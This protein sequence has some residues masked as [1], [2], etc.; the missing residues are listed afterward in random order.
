MTDENTQIVIGSGDNIEMMNMGDLLSVSFDDVEEYR[1]EN[2]PAG[3]YE[4]RVKE[5]GIGSQETK[6]GVKAIIFFNLEVINCEALVDKQLDPASQ[7]GEFHRETVFITDPVKDFGRAK[8]LIT[9]A[10]LEVTAG[11]P[12]PAQLLELTD[13]TF[14]GAI[15]HTKDQE[16]KTK[17]Y[18]NLNP[19]TL[20]AL[21]TATAATTAA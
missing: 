17:V 14:R 3:V 13:Q 20:K 1:F 21:N 9:D 18:A 6:N 19:Q 15:K 8:A 11:Q 4:F 2:R 16:D 5:D 12:V 10:S 7:I